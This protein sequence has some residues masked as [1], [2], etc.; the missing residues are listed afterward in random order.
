MLCMGGSA[1]YQQ[2]AEYNGEQ[3]A[4][5]ARRVRSIERAARRI[6]CGVRM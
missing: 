2:N 5:T 4:P 1:K 6:F 3:T